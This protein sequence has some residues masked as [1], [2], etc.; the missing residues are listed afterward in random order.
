MSSSKSSSKQ[1]AEIKKIAMI[2]CGAMGGGMALLF[3]ENGCDV[4]L[5]DPSNDAMDKV[6]DTAKK[7]NVGDKLSKAQSDEELC[8]AFGDDRKVFVW[9]LP[10]GHVGDSVLDGLMPY[11]RKDDIIIDCA[12]EHWQNTERRIGKS[13]TKA[14]RYVG[15]GVSGGY[16]AARRGPSMCPG[17]DSE[18]FDIVLPLLEKAAA[19]APDGTPC[20]G[21]IGTGGAGHYCKMIHNGIE[22]GMMSAICEIWSIMT[23]GLGMSQDEIGDV[24][25]QWNESGE[26][27]GTFLIRIGAEI[28]KTKDDKEDKV[29]QDVCGEEGTGIWSNTEAIEKHVPAP[30]LTTAHFLR[31]ASS[32]LHQRRTINKTFGGDFPPQPID[33]K[34]RAAFLE[35]LRL[36]TYG[37]CL[38]A[39]VQGMNI[40]DKADKDHHFNVDY[41]ALLQIWRAGCIIQADYISSQLLMPHYKNTSTSSSHEEGNKNP[42]FVPDVAKD[43]K[44]TYASLKKVVLAG[45]EGDHVIPSL[46][47]T[48]DY[49]KMVTSTDL[50]TSFQEAELDYFGRHMFDIKGHDEG[51]LPT[52]GKHHYEWKPA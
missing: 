23:K 21:R 29:V 35:H 4:V 28:C 27:Q 5:R 25:S 8:K 24:F 44:K 40:I 16:Q 13:V 32:D 42:L 15:C 12:N 26:L 51:G 10:H 39:Y 33:V 46:A 48:L 1:H 37:A 17:T 18:T 49:L 31:L 2:G 43:L 47:A 22:H 19:K 3:A 30:T 9:S 41:H 20:V 52:I 7:D 34:D 38:A 11:L 50:P 36:A 6:L 45:V 14:I